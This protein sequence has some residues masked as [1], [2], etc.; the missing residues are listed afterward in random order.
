M[1]RDREVPYS[2][3]REQLHQQQQSSISI[4]DELMK[5]ANLKEKRIISEDEFQQMKQYLIKK[6]E[7]N[8]ISRASMILVIIISLPIVS[9][10]QL[11]K[12]VMARTHLQKELQYLLMM[13]F[14]IRNLMM[15]RKQMYI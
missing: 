11:P 12:K 7:E 3:H 1:D 8:M 2:Q 15:L 14:R 6:E 9:T 4:A 10:L 5:L 13:L